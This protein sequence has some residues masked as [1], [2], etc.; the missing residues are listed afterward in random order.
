VVRLVKDAP[1]PGEFRSSYPHIS[2]S[3]V[4]TPP[5][6]KR[7]DFI[8]YSSSSELVE[9]E[10]WRSTRS[11]LLSPAPRTAYKVA[12]AK[13][14]VVPVVAGGGKAP[15]I[16]LLSG[17]LSTFAYYKNVD[18]S[19]YLTSAFPFPSLRFYDLSNPICGRPTTRTKQNEMQPSRIWHRISNEDGGKWCRAPMPR[20]KHPSRP[21]KVIRE[22]V[23]H[24]I[25]IFRWG[26]LC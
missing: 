7:F 5:L 17:Q 24:V 11:R 19:M 1:S 6:A 2:S 8:E 14:R 12:V 26:F 9:S 4:Q 21:R 10:M 18:Y 13:S 25:F 3:L 15:I 16:A 20:R 22:R 23:S